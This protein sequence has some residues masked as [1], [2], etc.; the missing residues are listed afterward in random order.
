MEKPSTLKGECWVFLSPN[1]WKHILDRVSKVD[2]IQLVAIEQLLHF[3]HK[4]VICCYVMDKLYR[5]PDL[6][7]LSSGQ[8]AICKIV[9]G[10]VEKLLDR[11][12]IPYLCHSRVLLIQS[13]I[14]SYALPFLRC[15][16]GN[17]HR[18][19]GCPAPHGGKPSI[20]A[21]LK[22]PFEMAKAKERSN[23]F[24]AANSL[25]FKE[26]VLNNMS[27][28]SGKISVREPVRIL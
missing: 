16:V 28:P 26:E 27:C 5:F 7:Y 9:A 19:K 18:Q 12:V 6:I 15:I 10:S 8:K 23:F 1:L 17:T 13:W 3:F 25:F 2:G 24:A 11:L 22:L 21:W 14:C 20:I 4:Q